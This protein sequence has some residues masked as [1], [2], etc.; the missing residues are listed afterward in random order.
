[1]IEMYVERVP[2][3]GYEGS[4][5]LQGEKGCTL[6]RAMWWVFAMFISVKA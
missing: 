6:D 2:D 5:I 3:V 1:M 4:C